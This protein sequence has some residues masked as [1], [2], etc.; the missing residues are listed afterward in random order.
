MKS[1]G[2]VAALL[3]VISR[4]SQLIDD[5]AKSLDQSTAM[6]ERLLQLNDRAHEH[7]R[8][9]QELAEKRSEP[10][11]DPEVKPINSWVN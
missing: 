3:D 5:L 9:Q 7:L 2:D 4:Q 6:T 8:F 10:V 1:T 11:L